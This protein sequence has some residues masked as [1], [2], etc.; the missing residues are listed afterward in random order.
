MPV[1]LGLHRKECNRNS[2]YAKPRLPDNWI[3]QEP[4]ALTTRPFF[5]VCSHSFE[6]S[7][8]ESMYE[9]ES[10]SEWLAQSYGMEGLRPMC[11]SHVGLCSV[12]PEERCSSRNPL[13]NAARS[14]FDV[15]PM[16]A[17]NSPLDATDPVCCPGLPIYP[18]MWS[19]S[20]LWIL[21]M[22]R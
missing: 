8:P 22:G 1:Q 19:R 5:R 18:F 20:L 4:F 15:Y 2:V 16:K 12:S 7:A 13:Q 10:H 21:C 3:Q 9:E 17:P 11:M 6:Q 14:T